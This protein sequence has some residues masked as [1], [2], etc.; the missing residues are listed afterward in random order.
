MIDDTFIVSKQIVPVAD[1]VLGVSLTICEERVDQSG[2]LIRGLVC[3]ERAELLG[4]ERKAGDVICDPSGK[5]SV[6]D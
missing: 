1:P 2:S 3:F 5:D 6:R 4:A